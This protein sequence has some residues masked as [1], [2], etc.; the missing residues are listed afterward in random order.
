MELGNLKI[1]KLYIG[2]LEVGKLYLGSTLVY[3]NEEPGPTPHDYSKDYLTFKISSGGTIVWKAM[4]TGYTTTISYSKDNGS[5]WTPITATTGGTVINVNSGDTVLFKGNNPTYDT[6]GGIYNNFNGTTAKFELEGN[7]MSLIYGDNFSGQTALQSAYTFNFMFYNCSGLTSAE[8][9]IL[10]A[11]TLTTRCYAYMFWNCR[12]TTAPALPATTLANNCYWSMFQNC[13]SLTSASTLPATTLANNCYEN[14]FSNCGN[15]AI[16]VNLP[17]TILTNSCYHNMFYGCNKISAVTCS[18]TDISAEYC[19]EQWLLGVSSTGVFTG[20]VNTNWTMG[21]NGIPS[22]WTTNVPVISI[23]STGSTVNYSDTSA[24]FTVNSNVEFG[25]S[26]SELWCSVSPSTGSS[27][28]TIYLSFSQNEDENSR[29][30]VITVTGGSRTFTYT[31]TQEGNTPT[32]TTDYITLMQFW[33]EVLSQRSWPITKIYLYDKEATE[34]EGYFGAP[35]QIYKDLTVTYQSSAHTAHLSNG[36]ELDKQPPTIELDGNELPYEY[37]KI[38]NEEELGESLV[39]RVYSFTRYAVLN[40]SQIS[41][42]YEELEMDFEKQKVQPL[43]VKYVQ[44]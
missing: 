42:F 27:T 13:S 17:A 6:T 1:D 18:A 3:Q 15:L 29:N 28:T 10:P 26:S 30:A 11:T 4:R 2:E 41:S 40:R 34:Q 43:V 20:N 23:D 7:I 22:N 38:E 25:V 9:L 8:N 5:S 31:L 24:S 21:S 36:D 19:T 44:Q 32:P 37:V 12:L 16:E 39:Y 14:M 35:E 33:E